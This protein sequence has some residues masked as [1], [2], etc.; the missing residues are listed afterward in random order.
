MGN[1][2]LLLN[3]PPGVTSFEALYP[4]KKALATGKVGHTGTLDK[5]AS[6]LLVILTG[7]A[8]KLTPYLSGCDKCYE[9]L[10]RLG[11]ETDTLDP[12]GQVVAEA[13]PPAPETFKKALLSF[14]G[15]IMQEPPRYSAIHIDGKR[16]HELARAGEK[17]VMKSRPVTIHSLELLRWQAPF[18]TI[19]VRCSSGTYIRSLARD[20]ARA[21]GSCG[22][23]EALT[24]TRV[25]GFLLDG[26]LQGDAPAEDIKKALRP[27]DRS[28]FDAI[29]IPVVDTDGKNAEMLRQ[30]KAIDERALGLKNDG[31]R[32]A[33]FFE[34]EPVALL[35]KEQARWRYAFVYQAAKNR[36]TDL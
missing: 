20:I 26:A 32:N 2:W 25:G 19:A 9:A 8:L 36:R 11:I 21:S 24:R 22:H 30:G 6:G 28:L 4:V 34:D 13:P 31:A 12:E 35:E 18:A 3:K 16:A 5:F 14:R 7:K 27:V 23:L 1:G 15:E 17:P 29:S 33:V 10:V